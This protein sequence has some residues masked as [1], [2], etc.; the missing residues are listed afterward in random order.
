[1]PIMLSYL[2]LNWMTIYNSHSHEYCDSVK[3]AVLVFNLLCSQ[4]LVVANFT[5]QLP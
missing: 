2:W 5:Q 3:N 1:M 4:E